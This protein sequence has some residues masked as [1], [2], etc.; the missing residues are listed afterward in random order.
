[1]VKGK[2]KIKEKTKV[3]KEIEL[4]EGVTTSLD[5]QLLIVKGPKGEVKRQIKKRDISITIGDKKYAFVVGENKP[6]VKLE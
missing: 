5:G 2:N 6:L 3:I 1:M 4:P